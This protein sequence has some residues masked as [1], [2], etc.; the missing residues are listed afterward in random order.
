MKNESIVNYML[1]VSSENQSFFLES[2]A[3]GEQSN[4]ADWISQDLSQMIDKLEDS[5]TKI[6]GTIL[7]NTSANKAVWKLLDPNI[8]IDFPRMYEPLSVP[9]CEGIFST[10]KAKQGGLGPSYPPGYPFE[11]LLKFVQDYK[12]VVSFFS[13]HHQIK[14]NLVSIQKS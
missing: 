13:F 3:T 11:R 8:L 10:M 2:V 12:D 4:S 1:L 9:H 14:S 7:D 5:G 6:S